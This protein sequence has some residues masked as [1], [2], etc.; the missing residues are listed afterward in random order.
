MNKNYYNQYIYFPD[1]ICISP[2]QTINIYVRKHDQYP[3]EGEDSIFLLQDWLRP[4]AM[5]PRL[6]SYLPIDGRRHGF[7][8]FLSRIRA[9]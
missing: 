5:E 3:T 9:I 4:K 6:P 2:L 1:H 7:I 8:S